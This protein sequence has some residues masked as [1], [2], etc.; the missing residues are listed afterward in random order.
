MPLLGRAAHSLNQNSYTFKNGEDSSLSLAKLIGTSIIVFLNVVR[1][2]YYIYLMRW[3]DFTWHDWLTVEID[4][5][6]P[7]YNKQL[8]KV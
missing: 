5:N 4:N 6:G 7:T 2:R 1:F 8:Y 3:Y